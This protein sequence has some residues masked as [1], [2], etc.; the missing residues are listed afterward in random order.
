MGFT[1][2]LI[3]VHSTLGL[4]GTQ[5]GRQNPRVRENCK[6]FITSKELDNSLRK[7]QRAS[8]DL[9]DYVMPGLFPS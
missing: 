4:H 5:S 7:E 2:R 8:V 3:S 1:K 9:S 6:L